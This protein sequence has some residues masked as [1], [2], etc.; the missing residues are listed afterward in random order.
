[1]T[2]R[3]QKALIFDIIE[4]IDETPS[5]NAAEN[6]VKA[7]EYPSSVCAAAR[8][9]AL[10]REHHRDHYYELV[11]SLESSY[12][13]PYVRSF[14]CGWATVASQSGYENTGIVRVVPKIGLPPLFWDYAVVDTSRDVPGTIASTD[15]EK[16]YLMGTQNIKGIFTEGSHSIPLGLQFRIWPGKSLSIEFE[17]TSRFER[18][19]WSR[20]IKNSENEIFTRE[21]SRIQSYLPLSRDQITF[22]FK[23][24]EPPCIEKSELVFSRSVNTSG[25][26]GY[27][28]SCE[29]RMVYQLYLPD[30]PGVT[31]DR[32]KSCIFEGTNAVASG[33]VL[34]A[35]KSD[36][37]GHHQGQGHDMFPLALSVGEMLSAPDTIVVN[38]TLANCFSFKFQEV[39]MLKC[40]A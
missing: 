3:A 37:A 9:L 25:W 33:E 2:R 23:E 35:A 40:L 34:I 36:L 1:M 17:W 24:E 27:S 28:F 32:N 11:Q 29:I 12:D 13:N 30:R 4:L 20:R 7:A 26:K 10:L 21:A 38:K 8:S 16:R 22:T 5:T 6:D 31:A 15:P 39:D 19:L 18:V 14:N